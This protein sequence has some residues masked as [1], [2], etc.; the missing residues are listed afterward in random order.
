[1]R[2]ASIFIGFALTTFAVIAHGQESFRLA[3]FTAQDAKRTAKGAEPIKVDIFRS[4]GA[5]GCERRGQI[6]ADALTPHLGAAQLVGVFPKCG[7][8]GFEFDG[9]KQFWFRMDDV[10]IEPYMAWQGYLADQAPDLSCVRSTQLTNTA[11]PPGVGG[12]VSRSF[13]N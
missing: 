9:S 2:T 12:H 13:C 7:L 1:M 8:V 5:A 10:R 4:D 3:G 11:T 6:P